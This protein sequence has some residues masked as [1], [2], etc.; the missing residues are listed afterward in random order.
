M[1]SLK[2]LF[3]I[4]VF[5]YA[6]G[7]DER[8]LAYS[9]TID[10]LLN[11]WDIEATVCTSDSEVCNNGKR[12]VIVD[13]GDRSYP[14]LIGN[15]LLKNGSELVRYVRGKVL[16]VTNTKVGPLYLQL[17]RK[18]LDS[19]NISV[20]DVVLPDGEEHKNMEGMLKIIDSALDAR[21]DRHSTIIALGG[22]VIGDIA[23]FAAAVYL[24]G[25][26]FIQANPRGRFSFITLYMHSTPV[27]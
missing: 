12:A 25:V 2:S 23:G 14:I 1:S 4:F 19:H 7:N 11:S 21:L 15:G 8:T 5:V 24:R 18:S 3:L 22:G 9:E 20:F 6:L 13:L 27:G 10:N 16:I 17:V 26:N